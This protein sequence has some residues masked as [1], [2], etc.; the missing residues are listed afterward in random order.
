MNVSH[1]AMVIMY[2]ASKMFIQQR[3]KACEE[4]GHDASDYKRELE[5]VEEAWSNYLK[6]FS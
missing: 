4:L 2:N 3:I 1:E 6:S 5:I